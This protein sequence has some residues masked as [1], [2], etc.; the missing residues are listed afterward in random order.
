MLGVYYNLEISSRNERTVRIN[1][2]KT[3]ISWLL[4]GKLGKQTHQL[5]GVK[6]YSL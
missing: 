1:I 2:G 4:V 6:S 5:E 3:P